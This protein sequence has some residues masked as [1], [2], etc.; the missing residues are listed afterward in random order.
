MKA[1]YFLTINPY[2]TNILFL[3]STKKSHQTWRSQMKFWSALQ[4]L[5]SIMC[6]FPNTLCLLSS[7]CCSE[8]K[9]RDKSSS[10]CYCVC[11]FYAL[12]SL[13]ALN[14]A[15][16]L[17]HRGINF[18]PA[19]SSLRWRCSITWTQS[20]GWLRQVKTKPSSCLS[21]VLLC[22]GRETWATLKSCSLL[23][24]SIYAQKPA[25]PLRKEP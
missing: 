21:P 6:E 19:G 9:P 15:S 18:S 12:A 17:A 20:W 23:T 24:L 5:T 7:C 13:V 10:C 2:S 22:R 3:F 16:L 4:E 8:L 1:F 25:N 14:G 11:S